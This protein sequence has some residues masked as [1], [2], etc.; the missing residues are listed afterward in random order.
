MHTYKLGCSESKGLHATHMHFS[1]TVTLDC[2]VSGL[3]QRT[4][5]CFAVEEMF[6]DMY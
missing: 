3:E 1:E 5:K 6:A 4:K 2:G